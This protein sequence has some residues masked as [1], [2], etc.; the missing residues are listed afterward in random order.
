MNDTVLRTRPAPGRGSNN[1]QIDA[2]F[3]EGRTAA[4]TGLSPDEGLKSL[5]TA[6]T[7]LTRYGPTA[8]ADRTR[9]AGARIAPP[10]PSASRDEP[11]TAPADSQRNTMRYAM[12]GAL[13]LL[14]A[15]ALVIL[16]WPSTPTPAAGGNPPP[17]PALANSQPMPITPA[18][19]VTAADLG[20]GGL[21]AAAPAA[22]AADPALEA[23]VQDA[24][25][26][27]QALDLALAQTQADLRR[28]AAA[29]RPVPAA[30]EVA[31]RV[32]APSG[33][34][35]SD[36]RVLTGY[37]LRV[38]HPGQAWIQVPEGH[39][40]IVAEGSLLSTGVK[41]LSID[42]DRGIVRTSAGDLG[43]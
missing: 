17:A 34:G 31:A 25:R 30:R 8:L 6:L 36:G 21:A 23:R 5:P 22:A 35:A 32:S 28:L 18:P 13:A 10:S 14:L 2:M 1:T 41:V 38:I 15:A 19:P 37:V 33:G 39:V 43:G 40:E 12:F 11:L 9:L 16:I 4:A 26:R 20:A 7:E 24:E 29:P 3:G 27:L 42:A